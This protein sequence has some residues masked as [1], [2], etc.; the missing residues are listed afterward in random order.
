MCVGSKHCGRQR[1]IE[2][3]DVS[4]LTQLIFGRAEDTWGS[5]RILQLKSAD[6]WIGAVLQIP[7]FKSLRLVLVRE[8]LNPS[9][10][11]LPSLML[12]S[13]SK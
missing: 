11:F 9:M 3:G 12:F 5:G 8:M 13:T 1:G 6:H 4:S 10:L 7:S 2:D